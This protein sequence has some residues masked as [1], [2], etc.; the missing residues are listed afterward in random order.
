[1]PAAFRFQQL[2]MPHLDNAG[3]AGVKPVY[4]VKFNFFE[5]WKHT[6]VTTT[7][8]LPDW[9][10]PAFSQA[11]VPANQLADSI[12]DARQRANTV[13]HALQSDETREQQIY[14][15][16]PELT[17]RKQ[18]LELRRRE[19]ARDPETREQSKGMWEEVKQ[20]ETQLTT[21]L[22]DEVARCLHVRDLD[23]YNSRGALLPWAVAMAGESH[24]WRMIEQAEIYQET[25][26]YS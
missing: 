14:Q 1:M 2:V 9:A 17:E 19:L 15:L 8:R 24:Y 16:F 20:L 5:Y 21:K 7:V 12:A 18:D 4:R 22:V 6:D 23:Y 11:E 10:V 3:K 13:L 25:S 26:E